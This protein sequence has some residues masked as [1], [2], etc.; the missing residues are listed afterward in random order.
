MIKVSKS[1]ENMYLLRSLMALL[2]HGGAAPK[3]YFKELIMKDRESNHGEMDDDYNSVKMILSG[4]L[5]E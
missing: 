4:I 2:C 5:L 3:E 1:H